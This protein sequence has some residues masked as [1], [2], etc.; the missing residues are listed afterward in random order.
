LYFLKKI[1]AV[2]FIIYHQ[3]LLDDTKKTKA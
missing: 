2:L 1:N 3:D